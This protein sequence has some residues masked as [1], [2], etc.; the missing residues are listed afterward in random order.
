MKN[1]KLA[2]TLLLALAAT[3]AIAKEQSYRLVFGS[4]KSAQNAR[5]WADHVQQLLHR[6]VLVLDVETEKATWFRVASEP[7]ATDAL[8][9][10]TLLARRQDLTFWRMLEL[11]LIATEDSGV[12]ARDVVDSSTGPFA[13]TAI[14]GQKKSPTTAPTEGKTRQGNVQLDADLGLQSRGFARSGVDGQSSL[15]TSVSFAP[16]YYRSFRDDSERVTFSPFLRYDSQDRN[17]THWDIREL[18]WNRTGQD[19]DLRIGIQQVFWGVTEF[20]HLID[21]INQTDLVENIDEEDKLGQPMIN[22]SLVRNWG[23]VD[24]F[25]LTGFRER[26]FP[27]S[28]GRF[29]YPLPIADGRASYASGSEDRRIDAAI[30][31]SQVVGPLEL[32]LYQFSGTNRDPQL[33]PLQLGDGRWVLQPHYTVIDQTG[34][35]AQ[36]ILGDWALKIEALRRSGEGDTYYAFTSGFEKTLVGVFGTRGDLGVVAEYMY[37]DRGDTAPT[38]YEH[39]LALGARWR[40]ND[41]SDSQALLGVIW[42]VQTD[43]TIYSLE[44]SRQ[45]GDSWKLLLESRVFS[46]AQTFR[47]LSD[48]EALQSLTDFENK[49]ATLQRDDYIQLEL[50]RFF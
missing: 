5:G 47:P 42:D 21:I 13:A 14:T 17:R 26:T 31:W 15:Q 25:L 48:V 3:Y 38:L 49:S 12:L 37:D 33:K 2:I 20:N 6:P 22:L 8:S 18:Y 50:T 24:V 43:E 30:R 45:I 19:W 4:F 41:L 10:L 35:D 34:L 16:E 23:I 28:D 7:L 9:E 29:R 36:A 46:G 1:V 39:D 11:N 44:A 40:M 27:G 32:G